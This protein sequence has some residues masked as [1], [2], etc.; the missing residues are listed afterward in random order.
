MPLRDYQQDLRYRIRD[1]CRSHKRV[2]WSMATGGGKSHIIAAL[3]ESAAFKGNVNWIVVHRDRLIRQLAQSLEKAGLDSQ[4]V[5]IIKAG[6][7]LE[8][9]KPIQLVSVQS[10][11]S[12]ASQLPPP[13]LIQVD[14]AHRWSPTYK[15]IQEANPQAYWLGCTAT[16]CRM[17]GFGLTDGYDVLV[18]GPQSRT[19]IK[20]GILSRFEYKRLE[21]LIE[22]KGIQGGEFNLAKLSRNIPPSQYLPAAY[23]AWKEQAPHAKTT[24]IFAMDIVACNEITRYFNEQGE[25]AV[26]VHSQMSDQE[27]DTV[28]KEIDNREPNVIVS[29]DMWT[30]GVDLPW[31]DC[32]LWLRPTASLRIFMQ[33][34]GRGL[35]KSPGKDKVVFLDLVDN[36]IRHGDVDAL[37]RWT[38]QGE[39]SII[40]SVT[41]SKAKTNKTRVWKDLGMTQ[42]YTQ[43]LLELD[44]EAYWREWFSRKVETIQERGYKPTWLIYELE[45]VHLD[46]PWELFDAVGSWLSRQGAA[47]KG[48]AY[49]AYRRRYGKEPPVSRRPGKQTDWVELKR[50]P[51]F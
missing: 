45:K 8:P 9:H 50:N 22:A 47:K 19:L 27:L 14:E 39:E 51:G 31:V 35:R 48:I 5:G 42:T 25:R 16:P 4:A 46:P 40:S 1:T 11:R 20:R 18:N 12:R 21:T 28:E 33:I 30:E 26:Q 10:W 24:A 15:A 34:A 32:I 29:V 2:L 3:A 37:R 6:H 7:T 44:Q 13:A 41:K 23:R 43:K 49:H 17:N 36:W 38:L